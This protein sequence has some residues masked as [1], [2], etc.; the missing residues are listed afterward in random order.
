MSMLQRAFEVFKNLSMTTNKIFEI[1]FAFQLDCS[2]AV[3]FLFRNFV[4]ILK[5][6]KNK[7]K[8]KKK[9]PLIHLHVA[10]VHSFCFFFVVSEIFERRHHPNP[11]KKISKHDQNEPLIHFQ[12]AT[13]DCSFCHFHRHCL[14]H[15][16]QCFCGLFRL[17]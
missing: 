8:T 4:L 13:V 1:A 9:K 15:C 17:Y 14:C 6:T 12:N 2:V 7:I 11:K 5:K 16:L 3:F 10:I